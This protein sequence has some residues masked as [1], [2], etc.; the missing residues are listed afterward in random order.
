[1]TW[2][3]LLSDGLL[4]GLMAM[5]IWLMRQHCRE[6]QHRARWHQLFHEPVACSTAIVLCAFLAISTL[7]SMHFHDVPAR[8]QHPGQ[9][10]VSALDMTLYPMGYRN[11]TSYAKPFATQALS[12]TNTETARGYQQVY[13]PLKHVHGLPQAKRGALYLQ[14]IGQSG[15]WAL[16]L[17]LIIGLVRT[18]G[19]LRTLPHAFADYFKH[20]KGQAHWPSV[21]LTIV[22]LSSLAVIVHQL[23]PYYYIMGTDKIGHEVLYQGIKSIRTGLLI[24]TLTTCFMLPFALV[25]GICAGYFGGKVDH[26]IQYI[27]TT[28]S[29]IPGVLLIAASVL[30]LDIWLGQH[31][32]WFATLTERAD[33]RL[34]ALCAILGLTGWTPLCRLLRGETLKLREMDFVASAKVL[35]TRAPSILRQHI[36][37]NVMHLVLITVVM[38]F[39]G[40]VLAEA[41]LSYIGVGVDPTTMSWG[42]MINAARLELNR[43]PIVWWPLVCAFIMM[44]TL[45]LCA[46]LFA[47]R[48]RDALNPHQSS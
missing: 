18:R 21:A 40:L 30:T 6:A 45:V 48:L 34:L 32:Q 43:D 31:P 5:S 17:L 39:S 2:T 16:G 25:M 44:F 42:N 29:A 41:V 1:M 22:V 27:Y 3:L 8:Y 13:L 28:L 7:D 14:I 9:D 33:A 20:Q 4:F 24:G 26:I 23:S 46:N 15:L 11:E 19:A 36:L 37:P 38:D 12:T 35:G 47:D 10:L